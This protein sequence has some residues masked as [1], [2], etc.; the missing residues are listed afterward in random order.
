MAASVSEGQ[1]ITGN[2]EPY[3]NKASSFFQKTPTNTS[4]LDKSFLEFRPVNA[5]NQR[6]RKASLLISF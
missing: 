4:V 1:S 5:I 3:G 6:T 2:A